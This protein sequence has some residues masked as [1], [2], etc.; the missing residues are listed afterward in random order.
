MEW[1]L[2]FEQL[3]D[4]E[5]CRVIFILLLFLLHYIAATVPLDSLTD[6]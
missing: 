6:Y 3:A 2:A 4:L 5:S 1:R